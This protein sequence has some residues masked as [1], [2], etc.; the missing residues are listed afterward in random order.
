MTRYTIRGVAPSRRRRVKALTRYYHFIDI[1]GTEN[2]GRVTLWS[3][4]V[5]LWIEVLC[6]VHKIRFRMSLLLSFYKK[7]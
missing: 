3:S 7:I 6:R 4:F 1:D 5:F 2:I